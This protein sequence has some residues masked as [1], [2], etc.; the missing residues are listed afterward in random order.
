MQ[1]QGEPFVA[2]DSMNRRSF[3]VRTLS[4]VPV[5]SVLAARRPFKDV[6][7]V[8]V[9]H[10]GEKPVSLR[11]T[12]DVVH[13]PGGLK[14]YEKSAPLVLTT[15]VDFWVLVENRPASI[16]GSGNE[17]IRVKADREISGQHLYARARRVTIRK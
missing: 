6:T 17:F 13:G 15:P 12:G 16:E 11:I 9:T 3:L 2:E 4:A 5:V 8:T 10:D 14:T 7:V 1:D